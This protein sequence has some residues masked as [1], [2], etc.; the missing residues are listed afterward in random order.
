MT[1]EDWMADAR[2]VGT[3]PEAFFPESGSRANSMVRRICAA[4]PVQ[5]ECLTY[6]TE[7]DLMG[8]WG[9]TSDADRFRMT[10]RKP[11]RSVTPI[12]DIQCRNGHLRTPENTH[13]RPD[14]RK[15]CREC[16]AE[17]ERRRRAADVA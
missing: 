17:S 9:G 14:G 10:G 12:F 7:H 8:V 16:N 1:A 13:I 5:S 15:L 3:D 6:A 2:C 11:G 4:C